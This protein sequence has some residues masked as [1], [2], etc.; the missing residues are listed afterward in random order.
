MYHLRLKG[1]HYEM[2]RKRGKLF[3]KNGVVFPLDLD[4]FQLEHGSASEKILSEYFPE[5]CSEIKGVC[6][7]ANLN[8]NLFSSWLLCM[9]CCMYN[10]ETNIPQIR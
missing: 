2:G 5:A 3:A 7:A 10:L 4:K 9:G 6:D 8:Y 1:D